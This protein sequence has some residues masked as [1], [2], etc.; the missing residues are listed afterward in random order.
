MAKS[1]NLV[2]LRIHFTAKKLIICLNVLMNPKSILILMIFSTIQLKTIC[3]NFLKREI[4]LNRNRYY[5]HYNSM[6]S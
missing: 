4:F 3:I 6:K 2:T 1:Y 5:T